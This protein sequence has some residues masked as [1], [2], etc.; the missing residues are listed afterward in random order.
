MATLFFEN[1]N[2]TSDLETISTELSSL[3]VQLSH[4]PI[5]PSIQTIL[6]KTALDDRE[7]QR[8]L[9]GC[10]GYFQQLKNRLGYQSCDLIVL[11]DKVDGLDTILAKFDKTHT[12]DDDE[13]RYIVDGEGIF[14]FT[15]PDGSQVELK[16][17]GG[18]YIN[19]PQNT[20]HW[21]YLTTTKRI[22]AVRY[23]TTMEGWIPVYTNTKINLPRQ[24]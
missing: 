4:W 17:M 21:F 23:F 10:D 13:V 19:V 7:K 18:D 1:G 22:K 16:V 2:S 15:R 14:G 20:E 24:T 11:H 12:H 5:E 8:V 6:Q 9:E 3:G